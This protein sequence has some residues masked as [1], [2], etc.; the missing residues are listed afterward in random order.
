[1]INNES[2]LITVTQTCCNQVTITDIEVAGATDFKIPMES[3]SLCHE[4]G[5]ICDSFD[6]RCCIKECLIHIGDTL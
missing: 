3:F 6:H 2:T 1:M 4:R 5:S